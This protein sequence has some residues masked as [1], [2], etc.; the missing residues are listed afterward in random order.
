[1][2]VHPDIN[3]GKKPKLACIRVAKKPLDSKSLAG[4]SLWRHIQKNL[5]VKR[6][7]ASLP[8]SCP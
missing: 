1:M 4:I 2:V 8:A 7:G 3:F 6:Y 5:G